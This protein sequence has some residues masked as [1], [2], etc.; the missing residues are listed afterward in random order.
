MNFFEESMTNSHTWCSLG[1][2]VLLLILPTSVK[3]NLSLKWHL[4]A[5]TLLYQ[6]IVLALWHKLIFMPGSWLE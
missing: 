1:S 5:S 3:Q 2:E 4:E 6:E